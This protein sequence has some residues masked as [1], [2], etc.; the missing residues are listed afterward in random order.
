[1]LPGLLV[2]PSP[3]SRGQRAG[4][5][6]E[7]AGSHGQGET[8]EDAFDPAQHR[9]GHSTDGLGPA[10]GLLDFHSAFLRL[11]VAG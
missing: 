5:S 7:V 6:G 10:E 3:R 4:Q 1:M 11:G 2:G 8:R 9:L